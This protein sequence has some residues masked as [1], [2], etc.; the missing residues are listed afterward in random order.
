[1]PMDQ[2]PSFGV[3]RSRRGEAVVVAPTGE[4]D[5]ATIDA[6]R[7]ELVAARG[8]ARRVV[9]DLRGVEFLDSSGLRL[10]VEAQHDADQMGWA[11]V[12]V[13]AREPVQ[14]L[15]D[16]AGL[17][18]RLTMVDDPAEAAGGDPGGPA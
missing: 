13:R 5:L 6:V 17:S 1:M 7:D 12:V 2:E 16:I 14:R 11:F 15:L 4:I 18:S 3:E 9:L 10:I 8:E